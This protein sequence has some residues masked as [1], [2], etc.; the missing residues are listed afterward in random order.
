[1]HYTLLLSALLLAAGCASS[2]SPKW[3]KGDTREVR[4]VFDSYI[5]KDRH[6]LIVKW[7]PPDETVSD[8]KGG[9]ILTWILDS[10]ESSTLMNSKTAFGT[11]TTAMKRVGAWQTK[12]LFFVRSDEVVY[13]WLFKDANGYNSMTFD[14]EKPVKPLVAPPA[15]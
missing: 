2:S 10:G 7:G 3:S 5:N 13:A 11:T 1:M 14:W 12:L 9:E 8:A 6:V 15:N 4:T